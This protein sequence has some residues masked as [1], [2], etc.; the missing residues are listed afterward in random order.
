MPRWIT[1]ALT[2]M[3]VLPLPALAQ[4]PSGPAFIRGDDGRWIAAN[5]TWNTKDVP[6]TSALFGI[7]VVD[8]PNRRSVILDGVTANA[9]LNRGD[10]ID[11]VQLPGIENRERQSNPGYWPYQVWSASDF[12]RLAAKCV[13]GCLVR[14][15]SIAE[16]P[17]PK[18][19]AYLPVGPT[20]FFRPA[21]NEQDGSV[22]A[23][24]DT[25]TG[26]RFAPAASVGFRR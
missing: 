14:L 10:W 23:Y 13:E 8:S 18:K 15:R 2:M 26:E 7:T 22:V 16:T 21:F 24:V 11:E 5:R 12:Y 19:F 3:I 6:R 20:T 25:R 1:A 9:P 17:W 4:G